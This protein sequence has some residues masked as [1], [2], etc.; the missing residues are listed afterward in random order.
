[1]EEKQMEKLEG[2]VE[3]IVYH[4]EDTGFT[5]LELATQDELVTVVGEMVDVGEGEELSLLGN[6]VNHPS[7]GA[8][9]RAEVCQKSLPA[10]ANAI[11]KYLSSGAIKGVGPV[12]A[13]RLVEV[14]GDDT[15]EAMESH[16]ELLTRVKGISP[17]KAAEIAAEFRRIY[18][19][20]TLMAFLSKYQIHPTIC[21]RVWKKWGEASGEM[22]KANPYVLAAG[23]IGLGFERADAIA[24]SLGF[25]PEDSRRAR[26]GILY[27]IR[28]N[29]SNGHTC[30]PQEAL[31]KAAVNLLKTDGWD[32]DPDRIQGEA[33]MLAREEE[34]I[35]REV[36]GRDFLFLPEYYQ[37]ERFIAQR[38]GLMLM[39]HPDMGQDCSRQIELLEQQQG[40]RYAALQQKA[41]AMALNS[42]AFI[43]TGG[44][45]TGKT[46]AI[47]AILELLEQTGENVA[48]A[49]P[50]GR[51]AKRMSELTGREA[52]TI[53][54]LLEV[55]FRAGDTLTFK[56]NERNPLKADAVVVDEM[57]MVD[58]ML[59]SQLLQAMKP[60]ARIVMVGDT[61]QLPSVGAGNV[62]KDLIQ[63]DVVP[64]VHLQEIFRQAAQSLIVTNAHTIVGGEYPDLARRDNDFFFMQ[65]ASYEQTAATITD[66]VQRRLPTRYG[67]SPTGD[68]QVLSPTRLGPL[69]TGELNLRLQQALNPKSPGKKEMKSMAA[70]FREGDKVMQ[71]RNNYDI[72]WK[73]EDG[74]N[75]VGVYNGDIGEILAIDPAAQGLLIRFDDRT[76]E[77]SYDMAAELELA[78]A[79]TVHKSQGSEFECVILALSAP[80]RRLYYRNLLY[81]GVTRAKKLLILI[82]DQRAVPFMVD[83]NRKTLRYTALTPFL[84]GD[85]Q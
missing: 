55:D 57:S 13:R 66:L 76:A 56:H 19:I 33:E 35:A 81:T 54:R 18:G 15:L 34:L 23:D 43:L 51:A 36:D 14:F 5:V 79:V 28:H 39:A 73:K 9:F 16:S 29:L 38:I 20:R 44:P 48:L 53:H 52:K 67:F 58:T 24:M 12:L 27:V 22:I 83:N 32:P 80:N 37:A 69:G 63:A 10:T 46:T 60:T 8:Q 11:L 3:H 62:L 30:L 78:Y 4:K 42:G 84:R 47:N 2:T 7:Y 40:I 85:V 31:L 68:I 49:A 45:G 26:A 71:I 65:G 50:T 75:G 41:V 17:K 25:A 21:V 59:F 77:Y 1:M 72:V 61:D 82:G 70:T 6:Y 64:T 74:E